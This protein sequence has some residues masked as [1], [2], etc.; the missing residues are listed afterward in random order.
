MNKGFL[1][2]TISRDPEF[3][4]LASGQPMVRSEICVNW[5]RGDG[6]DKSVNNF[7]LVA[8]GKRAEVLGKFAVR[9]L[10]IFIDGRLASRTVQND[11]GESRIFHEVVVEAFEFLDDKKVWDPEGQA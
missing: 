3:R 6:A 11:R 9:G 4:M 10:R 7:R 2:G 5:E 8:F 1:M